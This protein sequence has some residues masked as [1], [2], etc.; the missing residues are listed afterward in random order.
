MG[1]SN[2]SAF[3]ERRDGAPSNAACFEK[4]CDNGETCLKSIFKV[5]QSKHRFEIKHSGLDH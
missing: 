3:E 1:E 4:Y 5:A 2:R